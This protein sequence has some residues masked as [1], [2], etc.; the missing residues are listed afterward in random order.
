MCP[1]S[2][3]LVRMLFVVLLP[4]ST[5]PFI[6]NYLNSFKDNYYDEFNIKSN[7]PNELAYLVAASVIILTIVPLFFISEKR[8]EEM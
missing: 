7:L 6:G 4:M 2:C 5:G 8:K 1:G 3:P